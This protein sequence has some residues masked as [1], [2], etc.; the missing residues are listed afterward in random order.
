MKIVYK[1]MIVFSVIAVLAGFECILNCSCTLTPGYLTANAELL[2]N[3]RIKE[4]KDLT[5]L[6]Y[7]AADN[8]LESYALRN[9]KA[10]EQAE[11]S[12]MNVLVLLDR[13]QD[14]DETNDNWTDTR[15]FEVTHDST[16]NSSIVSK[17]LDCPPL[18]LTQN[19][20]TELDTGSYI[21]LKDFIEFG[22]A[23][24]PAEEYALILWGHGTGWRCRTSSRAVAIDDK[25]NSYICVKELGLALKNQ[26][27]SVIGFDT[28]FA[29]IFENLYELKECADYIAA[30]PGLTPAS[31]WDYKS[32]LQGLSTSNF[33][34]H[35]IAQKI[36]QCSS[37]KITIT[38][39][40]ELTDIMTRLEDFSKALA[41]TIC[42]EQ[43]REEVL[44]TLLNT[45]S[46]CYTQFPS[47]FYIDIFSMA[48]AFTAVQ[49]P[50]L[51]EK[52]QL[53]AEATISMETGIFLIP[54]TSQGT[55]APVHSPAYI[56][57]QADETQS[58]FIKDSNWWVPTQNG[59]SGSLL[60]KLFYTVF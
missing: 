31:G 34:P 5:L 32:L 8:D 49:T 2:N 51:A 45:K 25:S 19:S 16:D 29:S 58:S 4:K 12:R 42:D 27:L 22:K 17:R 24:Y 15:I 6:V 37:S 30:S 43:S 13:S 40:A 46:Y 11:F 23:A 18:G 1:L 3:T 38:K 14:Y 60:D 50:P 21:V 55:F 9:L 48:Q 59:N 26:Q 33:E 36:A 44:E 41:D 20:N 28:C 52:S 7:M 35:L 39:C 57:N 53:L 56:K 47:D 54:K 10:M